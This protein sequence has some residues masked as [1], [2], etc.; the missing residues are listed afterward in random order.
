MYDAF[1]RFGEGK[2][3]AF[4]PLIITIISLIP[5]FIISNNFN[6]NIKALE[7]RNLTAIL[8]TGFFTIIFLIG[9][10]WSFWRAYKVDNVLKEVV[11]GTCVTTSMVFI[12]LLGAEML[13]SGFRAFGGE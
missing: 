10:A 7:T 4:Y 6:L 1:S 11:T 5:I 8:I 9:I 3:D 12:I 13:T 2:K